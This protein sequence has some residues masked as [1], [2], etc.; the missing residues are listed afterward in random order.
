MI[1]PGD[2]VRTFGG[3]LVTV[4]SVRRDED[5]REL[6]VVRYDRPTLAVVDRRELPA[7]ELRPEE[8]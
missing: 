1:R 4:E 3:Q 2:R 6:A 8:P 5:G 7:G